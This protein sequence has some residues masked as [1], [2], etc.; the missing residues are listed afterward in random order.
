MD[1]ATKAARF[2]RTCDA[3][4]IPLITLV[5]APGFLASTGQEH[6]GAIRHGASLLY[7][8]SEA[9]VPK[10]TVILRK[11]YGEAFVAMCSRGLGADIVYAWPQA[12]IAAKSY[13]EAA[14]TPHSGDTAGEESS[15]FSEEKLAGPYAAAHSGYLD[16]VI[17]PRETREKII[18]ALLILRDKNEENPPKKHGNI[19]F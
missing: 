12:E 14:T 4:G 2:I 8:Y 10:I 15:D 11:A 19:P 7:A 9:T 6:A 17:E 5:D 16:D 13:E 3:F 18:Q 1:C